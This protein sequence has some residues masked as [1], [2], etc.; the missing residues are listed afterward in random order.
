MEAIKMFPQ[1]P[2]PYGGMDPRHARVLGFPGAAFIGCLWNHAFIS[3]VEETMDENE[4]FSVSK[5]DI[6]F[7]TSLQGKDQKIVASILQELG[8]IEIA[9]ENEEE[10]FVRLDLDKV[11]KLIRTAL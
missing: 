9:E 11:A 2:F 5:R 10:I 4:F 1:N 6:H 8:V 3:S 7:G